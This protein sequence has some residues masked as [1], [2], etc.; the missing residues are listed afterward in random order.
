MAL[1]YHYTRH[2]TT[3]PPH[4]PPLHHSRAAYFLALPAVELSL[5]ILMTCVPNA[6][7]LGVAFG[8]PAVDAA[9][10]ILGLLRERGELARERGSWRE[11]EGWRDGERVKLGEGSVE[12]VTAV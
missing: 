2:Y 4:Q 7:R 12:G 1:L 11:R 10:F 6:F 9:V 8:S 5:D 3:T